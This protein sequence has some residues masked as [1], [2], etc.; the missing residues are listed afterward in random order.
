M[1]LGHVR[2]NPVYAVLPGGVRVG[3]RSETQ[4]FWAV[5]VAGP[6]RHPN[7][8][9]LVRSEALGCFQTLP[10]RFFF[11]GDIG[12]ERAAKI[13]DVFASRQV[14]VDVDVVDHDILLVLVLYALRAIVELVR[15]LR[16]PPVMQVAFRVELAALVVETVRQFVADRAPVLP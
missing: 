8:E 13:R 6:L 4:V 11:P 3:G 15:I 7:E 16:G 12:Q 9:T 10:F 14:A 1:K 2:D 5:V